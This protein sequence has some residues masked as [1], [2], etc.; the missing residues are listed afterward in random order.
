MASSLG[1]GCIIELKEVL[2]THIHLT[3][4]YMITHIDN[5]YPYGIQIELW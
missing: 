5:T 3:K 1:M 4:Y 2:H